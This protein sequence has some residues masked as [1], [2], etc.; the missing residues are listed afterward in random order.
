MLGVPTPDEL[1]NLVRASKPLTLVLGP[2][3][4]AQIEHQHPPWNPP[5]PLDCH[6]VGLAKLELTLNYSDGSTV[7]LKLC[8]T[9]MYLAEHPTP[10]TG[11][12]ASATV[13]DVANPALM[14]HLQGESP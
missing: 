2:A 10:L 3:Y 5:A 1:F 12:G 9:K 6:R 4:I 8:G 11:Q 14:P 13:A 7:N